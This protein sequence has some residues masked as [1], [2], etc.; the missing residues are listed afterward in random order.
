MCLFWVTTSTD[1]RPHWFSYAPT[2]QPHRAPRPAGLRSLIG[3]TRVCARPPIDRHHQG[4]DTDHLLFV[5]LESTLPADTR[6]T[7]LRTS[8]LFLPAYFTW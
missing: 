6:H 1:T 5:G 7:P 3:L 4:T 8:A 2:H